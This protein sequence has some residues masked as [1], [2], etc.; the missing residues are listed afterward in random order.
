[1]KKNSKIIA[2]PMRLC[3]IFRDGIKGHDSQKDYAMNLP[4]SNSGKRFT[5]I[6]KPHARA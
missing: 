5:A 2:V 6:L 3:F 4:L 1:M